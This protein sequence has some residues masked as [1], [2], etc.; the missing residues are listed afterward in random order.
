MVALLASSLASAS[1]CPGCHADWTLQQ[2]SLGRARW[3]VSS[4]SAP[5]M[6]VVRPVMP[7]RASAVNVPT[8]HVPSEVFEFD[9]FV[10][11]CR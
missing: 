11:C 1:S 7:G 4:R 5:A 3:R 10:L 6:I 8:M 2:P 9:L